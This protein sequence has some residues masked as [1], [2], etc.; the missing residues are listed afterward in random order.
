MKDQKIRV[1]DVIAIGPAVWW[2][3]MLLAERRP[4]LGA[5]LVIT[6]LGTVVYNLSNY[7]KRQEQ[8]ASRARD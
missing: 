3:G 7:R 4:G 6:G 5:F 8:V 2:A 1:L